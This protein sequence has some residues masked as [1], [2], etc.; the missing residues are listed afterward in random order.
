MRGEV[1]DGE[2][3][4]GIVRAFHIEVPKRLQQ[5]F[6]ALFFEASPVVA[7]GGVRPYS[8]RS[9]LLI[10][11][12]LPWSGKRELGSCLVKEVVPLA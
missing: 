5:A 4:G 2:A 7:H 9:C 8:R 10:H 1:S 11:I 6:T 3:S 12:E